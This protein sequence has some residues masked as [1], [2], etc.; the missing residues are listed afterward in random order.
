MA[1]VT[2]GAARA[3]GLPAT[4]EFAD[5]EA[6]AEAVKGYLRAGDLLLLK[7]SRATKLER[8][9]EALRTPVAGGKL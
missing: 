7:A 8:L 6:A 3:A 4:D 1:G 9:A 5:A 2:A